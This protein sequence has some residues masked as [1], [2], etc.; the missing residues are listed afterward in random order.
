[1]SRH[2]LDEARFRGR[3]GAGAL[4]HRLG[5]Y[6][7]LLPVNQPRPRGVARRLQSYLMNYYAQASCVEADL[8]VPGLDV[9]FACDL[10]DHM[11]VHYVEGLDPIYELPEIEHCRKQVR[12]EDH[13]VDVGANHGFWG[14]SMARRAGPRARLYLAEAN[15]A[16]LRRLRRTLRLNSGLRAEILPYAIG[17]GGS[18]TVTFYLPRGNLSGLGSTVLHEYAKQ[19]GYLRA[20]SRTEVPSRSLDGLAAQGRIAGMDLLKIDVERGE[21]AV[22]RGARD[23][24]GTFRPRLVMMETANHGY[25]FNALCQMGYRSYRLDGRGE[26]RSVTGGEPFWG[27]VFFRRD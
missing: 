19:H 24:L 12:P 3:V 9:T 27:N 6:Q 14:L 8:F 4:L 15:P 11:L 20:E 26:E 10:K 22:I 13:I 23:A 1:V 25:A 16:I 17:D 18:E 21:D 7:R 5:L 2:W